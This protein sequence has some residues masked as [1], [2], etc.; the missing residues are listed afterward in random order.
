MKKYI[1]T[2]VIM[3]ESM[4]M[5]EAQKVLGRELKPSTLAHIIIKTKMNSRA[6][7]FYDIYDYKD[8]CKYYRKIVFFPYL[9]IEKK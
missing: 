1:G 8:K 6:W 3:A 9:K 7:Y 2:K 5:T 4:T